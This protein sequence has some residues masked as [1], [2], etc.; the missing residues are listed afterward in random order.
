MPP[1]RSPCVIHPTPTKTLLTTT[2][3]SLVMQLSGSLA[4]GTRLMCAGHDTL[5]A[6]R[7]EVN[8]K[9]AVIGRKGNAKKG[10]GH[11]QKWRV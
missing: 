3:E 10:Q 9:P 7:K 2:F 6:N 11:V 8:L 1:T 4:R 5:T